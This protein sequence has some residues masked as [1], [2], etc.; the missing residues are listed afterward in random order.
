[1]V[2]PALLQ[3]MSSPGELHGSDAVKFTLRAFNAATCF[4]RDDG[5]ETG[6]DAGARGVD[7]RGAFLGAGEDGASLGELAGEGAGLALPLGAAFGA[8]DGGNEGAF[9]EC[10]G[11]GETGEESGEETGGLAGAVGL[12]LGLG[13]GAAGAGDVATGVAFGDGAARRGGGG[14]DDAGG[15]TVEGL[16]GDASTGAPK[17]GDGLGAGFGAGEVGFTTTTLE[18]AGASAAATAANV[19][20]GSLSNEIARRSVR[21]SFHNLPCLFILPCFKAIISDRLYS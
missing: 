11:I 3:C 14:G 12:G 16:G 5:P 8:D 20:G 10:D 9:A 13:L 6:A 21:G 19:K 18:G 4:L 17:D 1:M 15:S 2:V 7:N